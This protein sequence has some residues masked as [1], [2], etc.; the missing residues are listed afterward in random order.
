MKLSF[1][2]F[3]GINGRCCNILLLVFCL[4]SSVTFAEGSVSTRSELGLP[5]KTVTGIVKDQNEIPLPGV[6]VKVKGSNL[7]TV[8]DVDGKFTI[9]VPEGSNVLVISFL[10]FQSQEVS[11]D[12]RSSINVSLREDVA[13]LD[14]VLVIGYGT[15][16]RDAVTT[17]IS[18][19]D[20]KVLENVPYTNLAT[21]MQGTLAGVRVQTPSGQPGS[22]PQVIVRGGTSIN[23][24]NGAAP[25]YIV[26]GVIRPQ[27]NDISADDVESM[28]VLKDAAATAIYGARGS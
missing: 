18:K 24:P 8:T 2:K 17:S 3:Y 25:L 28:Q 27:L 16:S 7:G 1:T 14:E 12:S 4:I 19:L 20:K 9:N 5:P 10:G 23:N 13:R 11:V 6:S 21:A 15:Q 26:D 22:A